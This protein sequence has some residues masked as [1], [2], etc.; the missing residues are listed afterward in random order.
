MARSSIPLDQKSKC[1]VEVS[2]T[3][4]N[5]FPFG[6]K[7]D[8]LARHSA[9]RVDR[10]GD[11]QGGADRRGNERRRLRVFGQWDTGDK[12]GSSNE[13][14]FVDGPTVVSWVGARI[15]PLSRTVDLRSDVSTPYIRTIGHRSTIQPRT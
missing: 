3:R 8:Y 7:I 1:T 2:R 12:R 14:V 5:R 15:V 13:A 11:D 6:R 10:L 9:R 4:N